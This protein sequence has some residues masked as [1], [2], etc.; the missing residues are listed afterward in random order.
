MLKIS[1]LFHLL[2]VRNLMMFVDD[3]DG[4]VVGPPKN[5]PASPETFSR[6][7]VGELRN[8]NKTYRL[9]AQALEAEN[10]AASDALAK[11]GTEADAKVA[12]ATQ[13][14][15]DR[16]LRAELKTVALKAGMIDLDGLKLAD[17][18][19]V[20]LNDAG[21]VEGADALM[22]SLKESKPYLFQSSSTTTQTQ[23]APNKK[24]PE[25]VDV[26]K[27]TK[28]EYAAHKKSFAGK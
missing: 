10:Q 22:A 9:K 16:I 21:D 3:P 23:T 28:E 15:N 20:K 5:A 12:A 19:L 17:L 11:A 2:M 24:D 6:E 4:G 26:R 25:T 14:A 27:M 7:Y 1:K 13:V 18:S 8:E